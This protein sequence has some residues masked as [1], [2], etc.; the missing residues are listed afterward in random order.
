MRAKEASILARDLAP[1]FTD[2]AP[3]RPGLVGGHVPAC[4]AGAPPPGRQVFTV[5]PPRPLPV[6]PIGC[7]ISGAPGVRLLPRRQLC[8]RLRSSAPSM[9]VKLLPGD[10]SHRR[11]PAVFPHG[12]KS[13]KRKKG[14]YKRP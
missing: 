1:L 10:T 3:Q 2:C 12:H 13:T 14:S 8:G 5:F 7:G 6:R 11:S 9:E 4:T